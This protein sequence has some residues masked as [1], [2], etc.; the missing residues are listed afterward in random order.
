[1]PPIAV[2]QDTAE[3]L[4]AELAVGCQVGAAVDAIDVGVAGGMKIQRCH[5]QQGQGP[6]SQSETVFAFSIS[7]CE[8]SVESR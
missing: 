3:G 5:E 6:G 8:L 1:M 4:A 7:S 2:C